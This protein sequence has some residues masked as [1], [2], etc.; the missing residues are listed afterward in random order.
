MG[1]I[2]NGPYQGVLTG[3]NIQDGT[4]E[5]T[6][7]A[8]G[9]VT[10]VKIADASVTATKLAAGAAVPSQSGQSGKYLTTDGSTASWGTVDLSSKVA[11]SGDTMT[12]ALAVP[13]GSTVGGTPD[14]TNY[15]L[16]VNATSAAQLILHKQADGL[17][18]STNLAMQVTQTNGQSARLAEISSDFISNW[19][20]NLKFGVKPA[21]GSPNNSTNNCMTID[22]AGR[23]TMPYQP[24]FLMTGSAGLNNDGSGQYTPPVNNNL[25]HNFSSVISQTGNNISNSN[26]RFTAPVAGNYYITFQPNFGN[27]SSGTTTRYMSGAIHKN[28]STVIRHNQG[29]IEIT[30]GWGSNNSYWHMVMSG[31]VYLNAGDYVEFSLSRSSSS[32]YNGIVHGETTFASGY[33]IG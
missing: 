12:G 8:D 5:T 19:G 32:S 15:S 26:S 1:Y 11:K 13:A 6:D 10:T 31:V 16:E 30:D 2:G 28:G 7:L 3:G 24:A 27:N 22:S 25:K 14:F 29:M 23:V 17:G 33:L 18:A 9:A 4:V 20:G 21:N